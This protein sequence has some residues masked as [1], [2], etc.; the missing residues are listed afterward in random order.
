[1][2]Q[3]KKRTIFFFLQSDR[4]LSKSRLK[5]K[6]KPL[7]WKTAVVRMLLTWKGLKG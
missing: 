2:V 6:Q 5:K 4:T 1:M 7:F 3:D